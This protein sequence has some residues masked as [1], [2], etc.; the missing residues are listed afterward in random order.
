VSGMVTMGTL[1]T[2]NELA[3]HT[4]L[5]L[6]LLVYVIL[7]VYVSVACSVKRTQHAITRYW[8][9]FLLCCTSRACSWV[10]RKLP[11]RLTFSWSAVCSSGGDGKHPTPVSRSQAV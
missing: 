1:E 8:H 4:T 5:L 7:K 11:E 2:V 3:R 6:L 9:S 10:Q